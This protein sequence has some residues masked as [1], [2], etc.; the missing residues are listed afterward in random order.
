M[1]ARASPRAT[2]SRRSPTRNVGRCSRSSIRS[3]FGSAGTAGV[4]SRARGS[5]MGNADTALDPRPIA[6]DRR[7]DFRILITGALIAG[8]CAMF[9]IGSRYP[10]LQ[11][12]ASAD[13]N[14]AL[15]TPLG[16]ERFFPEPPR[17]QT[18]RHIGWTSVEWALT[19]RQG[20][21]FGLL[22][23]AGML[24]ILPLLRR[25]R[26]GKL[27]GA[28]QGMLVGTPLGVCVNCAAPIAQGMLKGGS[29][30]ETAL[31]T[32]FSS[33]TFNVIVLGIVLSI[34]PWYLAALKI[35]AGVIMVLLISPWLARLAERP[36]W[37]RPAAEPAKLPG[38]G[39]FQ[40]LESLLGTPNLRGEAAPAPKGPVRA[41]GWV[42]L[43]FPRNLWRV[44]LIA[45][46]LMLLA[47]VAG[48]ALAEVLRW[49]RPPS[50]FFCRS[51]WLST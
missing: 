2:A 30:V 20:M 41:L 36:G 8:L 34:F 51:R 17:D 24:T 42:L 43:H 1:T 16:F 49:A 25:T 32:L 10:S 29:R 37:T 27:A 11:G 9:W 6:A 39:W 40:R 21:T 35:L 5:T 13:P 26:G 23:A 48:A 33:P 38:V 19:N 47:G 7:F 28:V 22:L 18:L 50:A 15:S 46:P 14:E 4:C 45:L 31:A 3:D 44:T 12:K